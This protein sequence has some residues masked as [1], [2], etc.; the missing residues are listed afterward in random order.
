[1]DILDEPLTFLEMPQRD[2]LSAIASTD[3]SESALRALLGPP[4]GPPP[5]P[6][7]GPPL[8]GGH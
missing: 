2:R 7:L 4:L 5:G 3:T 6:P 8:G 1:M